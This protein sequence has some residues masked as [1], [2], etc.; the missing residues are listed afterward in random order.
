MTS[1]KKIQSNRQNALKS[2]GPTTAEGKAIVSKN[3]V[4]H[5][6]CAR[7]IVING[8]SSIEFADFKDSLIAQFQPDGMLELLLVN[9]IIAGFWRLRRL[10]TIEVELFDHL[11]RPDAAGHAF[12]SSPSKRSWD[13]NTDDHNFL[14]PDG[15]LDKDAVAKHLKSL[16]SFL[17]SSVDS[18][19]YNESTSETLFAFSRCLR[20]LLDCDL[21]VEDAE[22]LNTTLHQISQMSP[23]S[24]SGIEYSPGRALANDYRSHCVT[25][26]LSRYESHIERSLFRFLHELQRLQAKRQGQDLAAPVAVDIDLA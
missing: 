21:S 18:L 26:R 9:R 4:K 5:G 25:V 6:L 22:V 12:G 15:T 24:D 11:C 2:T 7:R 17:N 23:S 10:G 3:A 8:E 16:K 14:S 13:D 20:S 1:K 19:S